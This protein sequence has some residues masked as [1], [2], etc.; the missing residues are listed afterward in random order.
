MRNET[1]AD[2]ASNEAANSQESAERTVV[3]GPIL[4]FFRNKQLQLFNRM[5][6]RPPLVVAAVSFV[7]CLL[8]FLGGGIYIYWNSPR[9]IN[10]LASWIPFALSILLAFMP[11][12][13]D[14]KNP[15]RRYFWRGGILFIGFCWSFLLWHQQ[16]L[17]DAAS[18]QANQQLLAQAVQQ[19]NSHSDGQFGNIQQ[20]IT[21]LGGALGNLHSQLD[22]DLDTD[23]GKVKPHPL[24]PA[25]L[26]FTLWDPQASAEHPALIQI[27]SPDKDGNFPVNFT[28]A[29][30]S[31]TTA[32]EI[33]IWLDICHDCSFAKEPEGFENPS[34]TDP[35]VRHRS[36]PSL[37][38]GVNLQEMTA[39]IKAPVASRFEIGIRYSCKTCGGTHPRQ[40]A[41][42]IE[43]VPP[44]Q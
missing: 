16:V 22:N 19:S 34:G 38:P 36:W 8:V 25:A 40:V 13:S 10:F 42:I 41:S 24:V 9:L 39:V 6:Y 35:H 5:S 1:I 21:N 26:T 12:G 14:M 3:Q 30:G 7:A 37:N 44:Q 43:G 27:V 33:D 2:A 23:I 20:Q 17:T 31:D 15:L 11:A 4:G 29:N 28:I 18:T 32:E